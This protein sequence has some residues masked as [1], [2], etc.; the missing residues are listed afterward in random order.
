M[1]TRRGDW[2]QTYTGKAFWPL[3]PRLEDIDI[4]DI[5]HS[6][7]YQ[8]RFAGHCHPFYSVAQHS[9]FVSQLVSARHAGW[10]LM[11]DAAEAYITDLPRPL[12]RSLFGDHFC[13]V[14][15]EILKIIAKAFHLPP[16]IPSEVHHADDRMLMTEAR[17]LMGKAPM[18]WG[19]RVKP[20]KSDFECW[21]PQFAEVMFLSRS[22]QL[23]KDIPEYWT[24]E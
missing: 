22:R 2:I 12:K 14:E 10:G 6:L 9:V 15:E 20:I 18:P 24:G 16:E 5:A 1:K 23:F 17:D 13:C 19:L 8:C 7:A 11:H 21:S 4:R 3:D